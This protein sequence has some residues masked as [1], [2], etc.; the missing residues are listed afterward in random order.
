MLENAVLLRFP[1][2]SHVFGDE[3]VEV[4]GCTAHAVFDGGHNILFFAITEVG[5]SILAMWFLDR[6]GGGTNID[7]GVDAD[8]GRLVRGLKVDTV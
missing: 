2:H 3:G 1:F 6:K 7:V 8:C 5:L 4:A